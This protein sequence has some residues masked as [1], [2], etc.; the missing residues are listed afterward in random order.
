MLQKQYSKS[1][2]SADLNSVVLHCAN[3]FQTTLFKSCTMDYASFFLIFN[4]DSA[5]LHS[6]ILK[7]NLILCSTIQG[8]TVCSQFVLTFIK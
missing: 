4:L 2:I 7:K 5:D 8:P 1:L 6:A 3:F